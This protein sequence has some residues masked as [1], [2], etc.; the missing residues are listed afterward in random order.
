MQQKRDVPEETK[1]VASL[2]GECDGNEK[3]QK[4]GNNKA[5]S[6]AQKAAQE[7]KA[8]SD[9]QQVAG[10]QAAQQVR[11]NHFICYMKMTLKVT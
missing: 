1:N 2:S 6:I 10:Q 7:A 3:Q 11:I 8:A 9:A 4:D 5:T